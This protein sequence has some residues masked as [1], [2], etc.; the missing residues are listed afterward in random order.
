LAHDNL[1]WSK[2]IRRGRN[3]D[4]VLVVKGGLVS[5]RGK[6]PDHGKGQG[7]EVVLTEETEENQAG[8]I[9]KG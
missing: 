9:N 6:T 5:A 1:I 3:G 8:A 7:K 2:E 4:R